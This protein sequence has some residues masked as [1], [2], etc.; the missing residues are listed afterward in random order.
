MNLTSLLLDKFECVVRVC[1][2][3]LQE[4]ISSSL[5]NEMEEALGLGGLE[6]SP[7]GAGREDM[8]GSRIP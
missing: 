5:D 7:R 3:N 8:L 1:K 6:T 4:G 2:L